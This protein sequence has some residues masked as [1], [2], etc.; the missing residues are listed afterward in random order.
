MTKKTK[1]A[2]KPRPKNKTIKTWGV[3]CEGRG[4]LCTCPTRGDAEN[5]CSGCDQVVRI[6][7]EVRR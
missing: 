2:A 6:T 5:A 1:K 7:Y 3:H 4:L